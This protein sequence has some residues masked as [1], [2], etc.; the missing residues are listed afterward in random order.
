MSAVA[1]RTAARR[2][3]M[4]STSSASGYSVTWLGTTSCAHYACLLLLCCEFMCVLEFKGTSAALRG[5]FLFLFYPICIIAPSVLLLISFSY[6]LTALVT[7]KA[8]EKRDNEYQVA[9]SD[10]L[11][12]IAR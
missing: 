5:R 9:L 12:F 4:R 10:S 7:E 3:W 8:F 2:L 6:R 1:S 11:F